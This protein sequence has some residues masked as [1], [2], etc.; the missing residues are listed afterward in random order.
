MRAGADAPVLSETSDI[1][2]DGFY[3][4]SPQPFSPGERALALVALPI[5][6]CKSGGGSQFYIQAEIEIVRLAIDNNNGFGIGC[7]IADYRLI[8]RDSFPAWAKGVGFGKGPLLENS[9]AAVSRGAL[10]FAYGN[11][12]KN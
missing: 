5:A 4:V 2:N 1:T 10:A 9:D 8:T 6:P 11:G 3:C 7:R 12:T